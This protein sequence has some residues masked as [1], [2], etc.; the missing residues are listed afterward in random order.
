ME[1]I[2]QLVDALSKEAS[3]IKRAPHPFVLCLKWL[4]GALAYLAIA[5][6][7]SGVRPDLLM[8]Q[9]LFVAEIAVLIGLLAATAL[10][11]ALLA[12]PDLYQKRMLATAPVW[13]SALLAAVMSFA[14][15][16]DEPPA[17]LPVHSFE[18]TLSIL[19]CSLL[20]CA[21]I[22]HVMRRYAGTHP[23]HSG[24]V[25]VLFAFSTGALWLRL[26][27]INDSIIHVIEWHYLPMIFT[28]WLGW[29]IGRHLLRW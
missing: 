28:G 23:R 11:A 21:G 18:C 2:E 9:P 29:K 4:G 16:A 25:A 17:P 5:L 13:L 24:I 20:P 19:A 26:Y 27:E 8:Q 6:A 15:L 14:W 7:V 10:S 12:F 3:A 1:N 22:F